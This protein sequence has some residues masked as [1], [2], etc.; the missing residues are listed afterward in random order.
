[1]QFALAGAPS[2]ASRAA[3]AAAL[4]EHLGVV[5]AVIDGD[6]LARLDSAR[7]DIIDALARAPDHRFGIRPAGMIDVTA[8]VPARDA[9]YAPLLID[10][11]QEL[12]ASVALKLV[13][14]RGGDAT[15]AILDNE[16]AFFDRRHGEEAET[17]G[18]A[19][20]AIRFL[21]GHF[22]GGFQARG[23]AD[24]RWRVARQ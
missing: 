17:G 16:L 11:E 5:L 6:F 13:G 20:D 15:A 1:L 23:V 8:D 9:V 2:A 12:V 22:G 7:G 19:A 24:A 10:L 3:A 18:R 21:D 4:D 14:G